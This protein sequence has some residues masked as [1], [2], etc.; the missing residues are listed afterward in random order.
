[1]QSEQLDIWIKPFWSTYHQSGKYWQAT[2]QRKQFHAQGFKKLFKKKLIFHQLLLM[3][4]K[5]YKILD[6]IH[7]K[8]TWLIRNETLV[9]ENK[10]TLFA[11]GYNFYW[12]L[13][14]TCTHIHLSDL[15]VEYKHC[16][17]KTFQ[18]G[19]VNIFCHLWAILE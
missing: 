5:L 14:F 11:Y 3:I 8:A 13:W 7:K 15:Y 18:L 4:V 19:P 12:Y 2:V 9:K 10:L 16:C 6:F 1:M 17:H